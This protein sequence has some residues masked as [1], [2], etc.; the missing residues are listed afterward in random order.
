MPSAH[1]R[2]RRI[3]PAALLVATGLTGI[4]TAVGAGAATSTS[5]ARPVAAHTSGLGLFPRYLTWSGVTWLVYD[6][7][8][9]GPQRVPLANSEQAVHVDS[10]GRLH[11][12]IIKVNG[13]WRSVELKSLNPMS[14]GT[15][16]MQVDTKTALFD[17]YTVL[18]MFIFRPGSKQFTNEVDIEDSRFPN[19]LRAPNNAQFAVQPYRAPNHEHGYHIKRSYEH[20][21]QQFSWLPGP[22]GRGFAR[23]STRLGRSAHSPL[24]AR[25]SYHGR[26][27]PTAQ[28]MHLYINLWT[29]HGRPPVHGTHSAIIDSFRYTPAR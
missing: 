2:W 14:Y 20:L 22:G 24:V 3:G 10:R 9:S 6:R 27:V 21:R 26:S 17:P 18:G 28:N 5:A 7:D 29:N 16:R 12:R 1:R 25:W 23:F 13:V 8:Q 11:L 15:F 4:A 19:L